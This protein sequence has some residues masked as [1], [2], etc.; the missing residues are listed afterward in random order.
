M[1][2]FVFIVQTELIITLKVLFMRSM[3]TNYITQFAFP[4]RMLA[5]VTFMENGTFEM[6]LQIGFH[7]AQLC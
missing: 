5:N 4:K 7:I 3:L 6:T 2:E 1:Q